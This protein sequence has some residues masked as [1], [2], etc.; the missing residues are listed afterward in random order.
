MRQPLPM[1]SLCPLP[2]DCHP[3]PTDCVGVAVLRLE[4]LR[5][6]VRRVATHRFEPSLLGL[7]LPVPPCKPAAKSA[8]A[9]DALVLAWDRVTDTAR[10]PG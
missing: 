5:R 10:V 3:L 1:G 4:W 8:A 9:V 2:T 6:R 7:P